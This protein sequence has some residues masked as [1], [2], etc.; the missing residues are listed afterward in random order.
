MYIRTSIIIYDETISFIFRTW[1]L[2]P[3]PLTLKLCLD[4]LRDVLYSDV[5]RSSVLTASYQY[6]QR[7]KRSRHYYAHCCLPAKYVHTS[8]HISHQCHFSDQ[9]LSRD[10]RAHQRRMKLTPLMKRRNVKN[11]DPDTAWVEPPPTLHPFAALPSF[12]LQVQLMLRLL[13][14]Y[15]FCL[16]GLTTLGYCHYMIN[17]VPL[18]R[19]Q[20]WSK[21]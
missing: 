21:R 4:L 19:V 15:I 12:S 14:V 7:K 1:E 20:W 3:T 9:K 5:L 11:T 10:I 8:T 2:P 16:M 17:G 18:Y 13:S 6:L